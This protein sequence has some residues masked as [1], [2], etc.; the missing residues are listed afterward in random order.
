[1]HIHH[2]IKPE[3]HNLKGI[4]IEIGTIIFAVLLALAAEG[5]WEHHS[6]M[7]AVE[8]ST[9]RL[10]REITN[11]LYELVRTQKNSK[12]KYE[13]LLAL[14][15]KIDNKKPFSEVVSVFDG[16]NS[17]TLTEATWKR[18]LNDRIATYFPVDYMEGTYEVYQYY[19]NFKS[20]NDALFNFL[21]SDLFFNKDKQKE[22][23]EASV[24]YYKEVLRYCRYGIESYEKFLA[25]FD[26]ENFNAVKAKCDSIKSAQ[27]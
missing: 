17:A 21:L 10:N 20:I 1:M 7:S 3:N 23:Y 6:T 4:L 11:N 26:K 14:G 24:I 9:E 2:K 13:K 5:L 25:Q 18:V 15:D 12:M 16:Y 8:T 19:E 22:A 27:N